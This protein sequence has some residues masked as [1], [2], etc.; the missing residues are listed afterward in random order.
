MKKQ[1][2]VLRRSSMVAAVL[3][4]GL[5]VHAGAF[6]QQA[7]EVLKVYRHIALSGGH[8]MASSMDD[9]PNPIA[10]NTDNLPEG[11]GVIVSVGLDRSLTPAQRRLVNDY[12]LPKTTAVVCESVEVIRVGF[13]RNGRQALVANGKDCALKHLDP[14]I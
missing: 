12:D 4:L 9:L 3:S 2:S 7:G 13:D 1:M 14:G 11:S 10:F 8:V 6:A 5:G